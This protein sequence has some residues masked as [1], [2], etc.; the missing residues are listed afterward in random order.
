MASVSILTFRMLSIARDVVWAVFDKVYLFL[1]K[2]IVDRSDRNVF[3]RSIVLYSEVDWCPFISFE[4][5][6]SIVKTSLV[7]IEFLATG[8]IP[9]FLILLVF[10]MD[11]YV[12]KLDWE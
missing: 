7:A 12:L 4:Y 3:T 6:Q 10:R 9:I 11:K 5:N 1:M 8:M 2:E